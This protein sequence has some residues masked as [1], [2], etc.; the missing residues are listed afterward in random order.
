MCSR[1]IF[2]SIQ[3]P[4]PLLIYNRCLSLTQVHST[5][6]TKLKET[7]STNLE[8]LSTKTNIGKA[9]E[10]KKSSSDKTVN[11]SATNVSDLTKMYSE[12]LHRIVDEI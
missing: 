12:K 11:S 10:T 4:V 8:T 9:D 1:L 2:R 7:P 6:A 5:T 3:H